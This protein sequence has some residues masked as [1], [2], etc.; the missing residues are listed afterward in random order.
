MVETASS[1]LFKKF[2]QMRSRIRLKKMSLADL[3][4]MSSVLFQD[5]WKKKSNTSKTLGKWTEL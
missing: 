3:W 4:E 5:F 2:W 1:V